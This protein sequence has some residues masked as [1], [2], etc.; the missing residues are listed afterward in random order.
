VNVRWTSRKLHIP[1]HRGWIAWL[2]TLLCDVFCRTAVAAVAPFLRLWAIIAW[3][4]SQSG[5]IKSI[6]VN[7]HTFVSLLNGSTGQWRISRQDRD[8]LPPG[9]SYGCRKSLVLT[10][11]SR[12]KGSIHQIMGPPRVFRG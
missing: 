8:Y 2:V 1:G 11:E 10:M 9:H 12:E 7:R 6:R 4:N 5:T 3:E